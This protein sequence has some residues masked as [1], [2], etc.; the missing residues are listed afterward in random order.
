MKLVRFFVASL[1]VV[2]LSFLLNYTILFNQKMSQVENETKKIN[3]ILSDNFEQVGRILIFVGRK[4]VED[5]AD[6][7]PKIIHKVFIQTAAI[8]DFNGIF[9]WS[10]FDWVN[11]EGYQTVN[12]MIGVRKNPPYM[13]ERN[14]RSRANKNWSL[15][16]SEV[17]L[18]IPSGMLII[19]VGVQV[20]SAKSQY[21]GTVSAG[22]NVKKLSS[23][24][25]ARLD[26]NIHFEMIDKRD[27]KF[28]LGS[29]EAQRYF[30]DISHKKFGMND[31]GYL[32]R[33]KELEEK[34]PY[35]I[36]VRYDEFSFWHEV[37]SSSLLLSFQV[38]A[39]ALLVMRMRR[40]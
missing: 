7:D 27:D 40:R 37:I 19:P 30:S 35:K 5:S 36:L 20:D 39:T 13:S 8:H 29:Y 21:A 3:A 11:A 4:I 14:Y 25:L 34:Y 2:T 1:I 38:I 17:A 12:T 10:L 24:I 15:I 26:K 18:G 9:S 28:V 31:E 23:F 6:L 16:F 33:A 32:I 22:I